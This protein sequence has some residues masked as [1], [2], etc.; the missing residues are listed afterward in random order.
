MEKYRPNQPFKSAFI[1]KEMKSAK[2]MV[3]VAWAD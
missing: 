3:N 1:F 2:W